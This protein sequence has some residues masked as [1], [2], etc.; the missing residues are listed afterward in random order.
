[1]A[2]E[3]NH[4]PAGEN[5][6]DSTHIFQMLFTNMTEGVALHTLVYDEAGIPVDYI[7]D[8]INPAFEQQTGI[9]LSFAKGAV[10]TELYKQDPAPY[11]DLYAEVV[12]TN[13]PARFQTYF[14][15]LDRHFDISVIALPPHGFATI[16]MDI[17]ERIRSANEI[18]WLA[19]LPGE[20]PNPVMR[21][22][23]SGRFLY[24]NEASNFVI[25][26]LNLISNNLSQ[27]KLFETIQTV[28]KENSSCEIEL[29][30]ENR[31]ITFFVTAIP[32]EKYV[33]IYGRDITD[34]KNA[35]KDLARQQE[36]LLRS[37]A[38]L[39]Q[40]AYVASHDL[41]EPLRMV[42]SYVQL[43]ARRYKGRLDQ[44]ADEF[45]NYAVDGATRMSTLINDLLEFSR[46]GRRGDTF[47]N[48]S[49]EAALN[50]A[51][52][53]LKSLIVES[54]AIINHDS[55]PI[56]Y[57]DRSEITQVFQNL[58][59]NSIKFRRNEL[60]VIDISARL[61]E[62]KSS[63]LFS[64]KDN[65]IGIDPQFHD[66]I[67]IIFQRLH[68]RS[69]YHGTGIGLAICKKII[70]FH[71]GKIWVEST[72]GNGSVFYFTIPNKNTL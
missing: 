27:G 3:Q 60:P 14:P 66:R 39:E 22:D 18:K 45:I 2:P 52:F 28:S 21:F 38:E 19:K 5:Q 50:T 54:N 16:F 1:M 40:F 11:L 65:G 49:A 23:Q 20:N 26:N 34:K 32:H 43:L 36:E 25:N 10:A 58:I 68:G 70:Q 46:I 9:L 12:S 17:T 35:E 57:A 47:S 30:I 4:L 48:I 55:L 63:W 61:S 33:N 64:V 56:I 37:N 51:M 62:D 71:K 8:D 31:I 44:D 42:T 69:E 15:P 67:F 6:Q 24:A 13:K 41:Q 72:E 53:N 29:E 7:I 59:A